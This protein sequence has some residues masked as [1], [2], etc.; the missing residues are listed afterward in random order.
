METHPAFHGRY[1]IHFWVGNPLLSERDGNNKG[2]P[3]CWNNVFWVGNPLLSERDGNCKLNRNAYFWVEWWSETHYS[4]KEMETQSHSWYTSFCLELSRKPTTLWKR[5]K[6]IFRGGMQVFGFSQ[7][8]NPLLSERDGNISP[9]SLL[10]FEFFPR[11]GNPL[12]SERDGNS[13][14]LYPSRCLWSYTRRKPTTLWKR[15]KHKNSTVPQPSNKIA[16]GNPLLSERDG[17]HPKATLQH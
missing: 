12:L 15:W 10:V 11:V 6:L 5:W 14:T 3:L 8:G 4:L 16:V 1:N 2:E 13:T 17:N 7:V 9:T